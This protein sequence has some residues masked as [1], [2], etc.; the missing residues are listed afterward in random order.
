MREVLA[1]RGCLAGG[2]PVLPWPSSVRCCEKVASWCAS[3]LRPGFI[4]VASLR[5]PQSL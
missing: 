3:R 5:A 1:S 2:G 4:R